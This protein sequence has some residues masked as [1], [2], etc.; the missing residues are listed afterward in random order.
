MYYLSKSDR[1]IVAVAGTGSPYSVMHLGAPP[2]PPP[3]M[4]TTTETRVGELTPPPQLRNVEMSPIE[5]KT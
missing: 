3:P 2:P 4:T 5:K 1:I